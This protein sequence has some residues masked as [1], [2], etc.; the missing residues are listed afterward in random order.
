M[1]SWPIT[2]ASSLERSLAG[3]EAAALAGEDHVQLR[4]RI[5]RAVRRALGFE[6]ACTATVDPVTAMWTHC[7]L[8]GMERDHAFEA[9][10]FDA[11]YREHDVAPLAEVARRPR[12]VSILRDDAGA[13]PARS[14]RYRELYRPAGISDE[15]RVLLLDGG[16]PWGSLHLLRTGGARF[17]AEEADAVVQVAPGY[18]RA[19][20]HAVLRAAALGAGKVD[21]EPPGL[22]LIE[23]DGRIAEASPEAQA[24][25]G[26]PLVSQLPAAVHG[27]VASV[28]AGHAAQTAAPDPRGGFLSFHGTLLGERVA[29]IVERTRP[30]ELAEVVVRALG[31]TAREREVLEHVV[32]GESTKEIATALGI[33]EWTVQDHLKSIFAKTA[34][35][36]RQELVAALFFGHWAP[37]HA[38]GTP[39]S[40]Y[41]HYLRR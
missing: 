1:L 12:P 18:A 4:T 34:T 25:L 7:A 2:L 40:P 28:R 32:R 3:I 29:V 9:R 5:A 26:M 8:E 11:E 39:P 24:L 15:L 21:R 31:L 27:V 22:V 37:E 13:D 30:P 38:R 10:I 23:S 41:G 17:T 6:I 14:F 33:K 16:T 19:L 20:R 36:T 35:T